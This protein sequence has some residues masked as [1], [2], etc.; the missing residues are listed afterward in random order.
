MSYYLSD[1]SHVLISGA[2]GAGDDYGGKSVLA[3]WWFQKSVSKNHHD[4]G[5]FFDPKGL[6]YVERGDVRRVQSLKGLAQSYRAGN[7][8]FAY[9][10]RATGDDLE[11]EHDR[12]VATL[13]QLPGRKIMVHDEAQSFADGSLRWCLSQGGN[14][15][16][17]A[18]ET[19]DIRSLVV[20]QRPWNLSE[21]LRANMP[22]KIWVGPFG[23]EARK[24]FQSEQMSGAAAKVESNT[25]PYRWSVTDGGDY[26]TTHAPVPEDFA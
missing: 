26:I 14:M 11:A 12:V 25:G 15:S 3:N 9:H 7:R 16:N 17:S 6:S 8:L 10:P 20:T 1:G 4:M 2:T 24:F 22:L 18:E 21:T 13:R 23:N 19:D 5:L